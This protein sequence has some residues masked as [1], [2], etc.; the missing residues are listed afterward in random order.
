MYLSLLLEGFLRAGKKPEAI[1]VERQAMALDKR[2]PSLHS[3]D[4][5]ITTYEDLEMNDD[6]LRIYKSA[7][8]FRIKRATAAQKKTDLA[9]LCLVNRL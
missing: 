9:D 5:V 7:I 4:F 2:S 8:D 3:F 1:A 6:A